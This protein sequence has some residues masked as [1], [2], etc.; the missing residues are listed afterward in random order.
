MGW[1]CSGL[2][3]LCKVKAVIPITGAEEG[4]EEGR[5]RTGSGLRTATRHLPKKASGFVPDFR[6]HW[7]SPLSLQTVVREEHSRLGAFTGGGPG[8]H[9]GIS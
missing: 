3:Y 9:Q 8:K 6:P 5:E 2:N 1:G 4:T 7:L